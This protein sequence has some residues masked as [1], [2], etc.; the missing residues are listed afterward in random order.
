MFTCDQLPAMA[1]N[2]H[3]LAQTMIELD[4]SND[5]PLYRETEV[6]Q[7]S[8]TASVLISIVLVRLNHVKLLLCGHF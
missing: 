7:H 2:Y 8:G 1:R 3:N 4:I 6:W 5:R